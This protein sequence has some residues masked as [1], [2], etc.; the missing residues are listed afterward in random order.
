MSDKATDPNREPLVRLQLTVPRSVLWML[1]GA[2][3]GNLNDVAPLLN[4]LGRLLQ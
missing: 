3:L 4:A 1:A 2:L